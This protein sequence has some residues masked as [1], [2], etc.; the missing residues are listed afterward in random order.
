[1]SM[2]KPAGWSR[3]NFLKGAAAGLAGA[4]LLA[5]SLRESA[6]GAA[7]EEGGRAPI[8]RA[9]GRTGLRAPIVGLGV[10]NADQPELVR[11][12][13]DVGMRHFDTAAYYERGRNEEMVGRVIQETGA[14]SE[15]VIATKIYVPHAQRT[16]TDR[17][18]RDLYLRTAEESLR[19]LRT[20][21]V[22][23]LYSHSVKEPDWLEK[24]G[25][26]E[27]LRTLKEQGKARFIGFS[28]HE[29]MAALI[30]RAVRSG[31]YDV[32]LTAFNYALAEDEALFRALSAASDKGL[33]LVAMKTQ[34]QQGWYRDAIESADKAMYRR[35]YAGSLMNAALLKWVLRHPFISW[36]IPGCTDFQQIDEDFAVASDLEYNAGEKA[37]LEDRRIKLAMEAVCRTCR[38]C[39]S[40]C[41]EG[42]DVAALMRVH[43]YAASY[44]NFV[45]AR[46]VL[47][48]LP[49]DRGLAACRSC[50]ECRVVC[51]G[52]VLVAR[53]IGELK[54]LFA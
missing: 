32:I 52:R 50:G 10:M 7:Q 6:P 47:A 36:A 11:R 38:Q 33:G 51:R 31:G 18:A 16:M 48:E 45:Q 46:Q 13:F 43:M 17:Q 39:Q 19:R 8:V 53:R 4:P 35:Y 23:I 1:M 3:R 20:D 44:H 14:R 25:I 21:Y 29:N 42:V 30:D 2:N 37:F 28:V 27:A 40:L 22:D 41:P 15:A 24:A 49:D 5:A 12:A 26:L 54:T 9:L 34:C